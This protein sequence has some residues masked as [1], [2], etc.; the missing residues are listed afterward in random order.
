MNFNKEKISL[1]FETSWEVCNKVGGIYTVLTTKAPELVSELGEKVIFIGPDLREKGGNPDFIE[2][3]TIW[4]KNISKLQLPYGIK[5]TVGR[6]KTE[7]LPLAVLVD[8]SEV[9]PVLNEVY[10]NMW[11]QFGVDSLHAYGDYNE[12]CAFAFASAYVIKALTE[13]AKADPSGVIAHF[14]EWTTGMGLLALREILPESA[15]IFTTHATSIGRSISGNGKPLYD[16]FYNYN[17]D[18]MAGELNMEAKHSLEKRTAQY[19]DCF[20]TVS[21]VTAR[22]CTQLLE[23]TPQVVTPNGFDFK[24]V[25]KGKAYAQARN[26]AREKI[27]NVASKV[28]GKEF[29]EDTFIVGISGRNEYRNKGI[30]LFL[31]SMETLAETEL[32]LDKD[33]LGLVLVPAW[34]GEV[35]EVFKGMNSESTGLNFATH[36]L[37]NEGEDAIFRRIDSMRGKLGGKVSVLY[38]PCYLDGND[39]VINLTYYSIL[40]ALDATVFPSYYEPWGYTPLESIA[41]GVPTITSDKAGFGQW[42]LSDKENGFGKSGVFVIERTDSNYDEARKDIVGSLVAL[43]DMS[44]SHIDSIR[45][46]ASKTAKSA[47]WKL[48]IKYYEKA[49]STALS[50]RDK[51]IKNNKK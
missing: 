50:Y 22:E 7:S 40:P 23:V 14:D 4:K 46:I 19:A 43:Y 31:D 16:Q 17:G 15:S 41:F 24:V 20:T 30:D 10:G 21:E 35:N 36:H 26:Q 28:V 8:Y 49:F 9:F 25:Q 38:V 34:S 3:K 37:H 47:D 44:A 18:Q 13:F 48:F 11:E 6:W 32:P 12:S 45:K 33:I 42:I 2:R 27:L 29:K 39:G 1:L 5:I 51:R